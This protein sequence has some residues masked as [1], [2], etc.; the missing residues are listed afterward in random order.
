M[1]VFPSTLRRQIIL[2]FSACFLFMVL[3]VVTHF[4]VLRLMVLVLLLGFIVLFIRGKILR[5]LGRITREAELITQGAFQGLISPF[6]DPNSEFYGLTAAFNRVMTELQR[7]QDL[8]VKSAQNT[9][10]GTL[11]AG[12]TH[13]I[14]NPVNN[15]VLTLETLIEDNSTLSPED[16]LQL[17]QEALEQADRAG[18]I[19]RELF[20]FSRPTPP[21]AEEV[22][23]EELLN[24]TVRLLNNEFKRHRIKLF[25]EIEGACPTLLVDKIGLQQ[26]LVNILLNSVQAMPEGGELKIR[27][28][29]V[30]K[31]V[32]IDIVD[33]G[34]GIPSE[35]LN[36]IFNPF[37]T[38]K[39][40]ATGLG[41]SLSDTFI[42]H[43]GGRLE[44]QSIEGLGTTFSLIIPLLRD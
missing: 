8:L 1:T 28:R 30:K 44:V 17:Y 2:A 29:R 43:Q 6:G 27:L 41:L 9:V 42:H 20:E 24:K 32:Q 11:T 7:R 16:R 22:N 34:V 33:T 21:Q 36:Q 10:I 4:S 26:V 40:G 39:K 38:T 13:E 15:I 25:Q 14:N 5:P 19:V 23:L 31:D 12:I 35:H 3:M 37:F 18:D